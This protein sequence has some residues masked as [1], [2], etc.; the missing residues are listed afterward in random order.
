MIDTER[1]RQRHEAM[2]KIGGFSKTGVNRQAFSE[3]DIRARKLLIE[4]AKAAALEV[5]VDPIANLFIRYQPEGS[6]GDPVLTGSHMDSQPSGGQFDGIYGVLAGLEAIISIKQAGIKLDRPIEVVAWSNEE[7]SRFAPGAMGS[8]LFSGARRLQDFLNITDADGETL[9]SALAKTIEAT[10]NI[11][12]RQFG[13]PVHAY[14]ESH[15]EQGPVLEQ[16]NKQIGIVSGIQGCRWF[17]VTVTGE[18]RH[19]G[20]TPVSIRKDAVQATI[21]IVNALNEFL[22]DPSDTTRFTVGRVDVYPNSPNTVAQRVVF[23]IDLRHPDDAVLTK[24]GDAFE[25]VIKQNAG[26]C[27]A[28]VKE[29]FNHVP[30]KFSS[31]VVA[32]IESAVAELG[33]TSMQLTSGAFHDA[34]FLADHCPTGMIFIPSVNGIS[35]HPDEFSNLKDLVTGTS[36]LAKSLLTLATQ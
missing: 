19:A 6:S 11:Q 4:W 7:G 10:P 26:P 20:T 16:S 13:V 31:N 9:G 27:T 3:E 1:L 12:Q 24:L 2:A 34:M 15:I 5:F 35:H 30:V 14:I 17:E 18:A 29:T 25:S 21:A 32:S 28:S 33:L 8:M 36:V 23:S 22:E